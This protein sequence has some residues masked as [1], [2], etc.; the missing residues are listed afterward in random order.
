METAVFW[1]NLGVETLDKV[2]D[3]M[4]QGVSLSESIKAAELMLIPPETAKHFG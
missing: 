3:Y 1:A 4:D 2:Y